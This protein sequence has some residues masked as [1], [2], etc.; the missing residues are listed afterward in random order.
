M[1]NDCLVNNRLKEFAHD[2]EEDY[3]GHYFEVID[4]LSDELKRRFSAKA[5]YIETGACALNPSNGSFLNVDALTPMAQHY[6][7]KED[8]LKAEVH[9]V[10]R[11]IQKKEADGVS[12]NTPSELN[13]MLM[14]YKDAFPDIFRLLNISL[15]IPVTSASCER[16]FSC[17]KLL[18]NYIRNKSGDE[19]TSNL[20]LLSISSSRTKQLDLEKVIDRF[21]AGHKNRRIVLS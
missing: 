6:G 7:V 4:R 19:R 15:T 9:Q 14:P 2:T 16:S 11:L 18:K 10:K 3:R 21:A 17:L 1:T 8:D 12:I 5:T 20:A 13:T